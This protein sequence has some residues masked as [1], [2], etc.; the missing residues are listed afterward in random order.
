VFGFL[1][2]LRVVGVGVVTLLLLSV[3]VWKNI[4]YLEVGWFLTLATLLGLIIQPFLRAYHPYR[5]H[6]HDVIRHVENYVSEALGQTHNINNHTQAKAQTESS[7]ARAI[8]EHCIRNADPQQL[9]RIDEQIRFF[10][11]YYFLSIAFRSGFLLLA[12][13]TACKLLAKQVSVAAFW[14]AGAHWVETQFL[15]GLPNISSLLLLAV[16]YPA[17]VLFLSNK[18]AGTA[19]GIILAELDARHIFLLTR[20]SEIQKLAKQAGQDPNLATM[21]VRRIDKET[22]RTD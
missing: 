3:A 4:L 21:A 6:I 17:F 19:R 8:Y 2:F 16:Y 5:R 22:G 13:A 12:V 18:F 15:L 20:K 7:L 11:F 1:E 9:Q 10:Y 14:P